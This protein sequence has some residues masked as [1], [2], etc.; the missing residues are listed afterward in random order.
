MSTP[1]AM[2]AT[3]DALL[4]RMSLAEKI[5]QLNYPSGS[6][7]DTTG[8]G[9][10]VDVETKVRRGELCGVSVGRSVAERRALQRLAVEEGPSGIPLLFGKDCIQR[11]RTGGPIPLA[12]SCSWDL[13]LI[14]RVNEMVAREARADGITINWAPMLDICHDPRWGRIAEGNGELPYLGA[15]IA[16]TIVRAYQGADGDMAR[17][18]RFMA[19]LKH[20]MGYGLARAGRDYASVEASVA[21][22]MRIMEPFRAGIEAGAGAIMVAFNTINDMPVTAHRVL[23]REVL[24]GRLGFQG[25]IVTDFT[26]IDPE[27]VHHGIAANGREA[28]YLAFK[29]GV[30]VDLVSEAFLRYLPGL[31]AEGKEHPEAFAGPDGAY[32]FGPVTEA[33]VTERTREVL[34]AKWRLGL[35]ADPYIGMDEALRDRV[36]GTAA[37]R[38]LIRE[39]AVK[40][41]V[42]LKN[43]RAAL[44]LAPTTRLAVIG[45]LADDR[46]DLQGTWAIDVDPKQ[47]VTLLEGLRAGGVRVQHAKGCNIADDPSLAA[48]LNMHNR[49]MPSVV[50]DPRPPAAMIAEACAVAAG[51]DAILL[52]L[53]EA[54]EHGGESSTRADITLPAAQRPLFDAIADLAAREGKPL[55]LVALASRPLALTHEAARVDALIWTGHPGAEGGNALADLLTG[56]A[57]FSGRL[58]QALPRNVGQLPYRTED[59]PSGRPIWGAGVDVAGDTEVGAGGHWFR[60]FTTACILENPMT[61]LFPAGFGLS[62]T[63][64]DYGAIT[65]S[66]TDLAGDQTLTVSVALRNAGAR[67]GAEVVQ[68]WLHDLT[69][70]TA[71]PSRQLVRFARVELPPGAETRVT[72]TLTT[73]DLRYPVGESLASARLDWEPGE[74][75]LLIGPNAEELTPVHFRWRR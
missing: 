28:A 2:N 22:L 35:F 23:L 39:A 16:E 41:M 58:S 37:N 74:F 61:P 62:Y 32:R 57:N 67:A 54:K 72:F 24:R 34:V 40:S 50:I 4:S 8:V 20:F 52:C 56:R 55:I 3:L 6:G 10:A 68:A 44:P 65:A 29:A 38:A 19:T 53:G 60:K 48:R 14:R 25:I 31:I 59:L 11:Y 15:R 51:A 71:R 36:T 33:E 17:P 18:D 69:G 73:E 30:N 75:D 43:E 66:A 21:T 45:P 9:R 47:S 1:L 7:V 63:R 12:L 26:A 13:D 5:G 49:E 46:I 42:L 27:L 64:F 70:Q